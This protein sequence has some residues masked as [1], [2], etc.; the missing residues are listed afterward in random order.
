MAVRYIPL[1][2]GKGGDSIGLLKKLLLAAVKSDT[3]KPKSIILKH[4]V[5]GVSP[6]AEKNRPP[7]K[8][9]SAHTRKRRRARRRTPRL[10]AGNGMRKHD[11]VVRKL[12][13]RLPACGVLLGPPLPVGSKKGRNY[14]APRKF[15]FKKTTAALISQKPPS[16]SI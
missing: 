5:H 9:R 11:A 8:Q 10:P 6:W 14:H 13:H 12:R 16:K 1:F 15:F 4:A 3:R 7:P 2:H